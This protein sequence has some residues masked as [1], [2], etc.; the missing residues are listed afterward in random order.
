MTRYY[1]ML[2]LLL[3]LCMQAQSSLTLTNWASGFTRPL[4]IAHCGDSRL[5]IVQQN[6]AIR[7]LDSTGTQLDTFLNI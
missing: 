4:D 7:V 1:T 5:F 6:G 3:P 2:A